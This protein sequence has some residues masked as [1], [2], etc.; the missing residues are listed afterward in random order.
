MA[1]FPSTCTNCGYEYAEG[2]LPPCP[3]CEDTRRTFH[4]EARAQVGVLA[5]ARMSTRKLEREVQKN[6]SLIVVLAAVYLISMFPSY[7]LSGWW[8]VVANL[9]AIIVSTVVSYY[10]IT[11][12]I[13]ITIDHGQ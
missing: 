10:T 5:R 1:G 12:V 13:T 6:W 11:R 3:K 2:E 4:M 9:A 7:L 8:S